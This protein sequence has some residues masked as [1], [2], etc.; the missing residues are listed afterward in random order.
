MSKSEQSSANPTPQS[1]AR[2]QPDCDAARDLIPAYAFGLADADEAALVEASLPHCPDLVAELESYTALAAPMAATV[3]QI[4]PPPSLY[5]RLMSA[6]E[7]SRP[8]AGVV[9]GLSTTVPVTSTESGVRTAPSVASNV[10]PFPA[11]NQGRSRGSRLMMIVAAVAAVLAL[12]AL[13]V[14]VLTNAL[15]SQAQLTDRLEAQTAMLALFAQ[16]EVLEFEMRDPQ[17]AENPTRAVVLCHPEETIAVIR[18]ENFPEA[19]ESY[20]VWLWDKGQRTSGGTLRVGQNGRGTLVIQA[21]LPLKNYDYIGI[22]EPLSAG[23]TPATM[24][25]G[26]LYPTEEAPVSTPTP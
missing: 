1:H 10:T 18:A 3:P 15:S 4:A 23:G 12:F 17:N 11:S 5:G 6:A 19:E 9:G 22:A 8:S 13:N 7:Q 26:A 21:P 24:L 2:L 16:D 14:L 20:A 25:R